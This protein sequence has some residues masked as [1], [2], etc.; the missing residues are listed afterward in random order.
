MGAS[1][2]F[3]ARLAVARTRAL[4]KTRFR[5]NH[6]VEMPDNRTVDIRT[7]DSLETLPISYGRKA[8]NHSQECTV[9]FHLLI[10]ICSLAI[11]GSVKLRSQ[12]TIETVIR[13][14]PDKSLYMEALVRK[15]HCTLCRLSN[16][17]KGREAFRAMTCRFELNP[18]RFHRFSR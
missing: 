3:A 5:I 14:A 8:R 18:H 16:A 11:C 4:T 7:R 1:Q 12:L 15:N 10:I 9:N 13:R 2:Y 17:P 6:L